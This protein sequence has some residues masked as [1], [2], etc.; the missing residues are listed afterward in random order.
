MPV[1]CRRRAGGPLRSG[2]PAGP[3]LAPHRGPHGSIRD[4]CSARLPRAVGDGASHPPPAR[5]SG[6]GPDARRL[7][8]VARRA[9]GVSA[10]GPAGY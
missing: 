8:P 10:G 6:L 1:A 2:E 4:A 7:R 5:R 3:P 9:S